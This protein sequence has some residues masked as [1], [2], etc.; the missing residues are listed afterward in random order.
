ML[1]L[2]LR[3]TLK[4]S[5]CI[6]LLDSSLLKSNNT[7]IL[8]QL[9][10]WRQWGKKSGLEHEKR[11]FFDISWILLRRLLLLWQKEKY[12]IA[13][14]SQHDSLWISKARFLCLLR[15]CFDWHTGVSEHPRF[16]LAVKNLEKPS[17]S[18][19][20]LKQL[21]DSLWMNRDSSLRFCVCAWF[22]GI[23]FQALQ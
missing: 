15:I 1:Q 22:I 14:P 6:K 23:T 5:W 21:W 18:D 3:Q 4:W 12:C 10:L 9:I 16:L 20:N 8:Q 19:Y 2:L 13:A 11:I 7:G 17:E